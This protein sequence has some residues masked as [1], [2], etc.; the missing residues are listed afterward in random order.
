MRESMG[1]GLKG[2]KLGICIKKADLLID[3]GADE[4]NMDSAMEQGC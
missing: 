3:D 4:M 2:R 1:D